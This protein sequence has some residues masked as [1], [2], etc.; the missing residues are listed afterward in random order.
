VRFDPARICSILNEERVDYVVVG[1]LAAV[2]LGSPL[3]TEDID[4]IPSREEQNLERLSRALVRLN[5]RIRTDGDPVPAPLDPLFL[6]QM[7]HILNLVTDFGILDLTF[8]PAGPLAD[9]RQWDEH[10]SAEEIADGLV[11]RVASLDD[12]ID[13]KRAAN[14]EKDLRALPYL[15]S[16]REVR[17]S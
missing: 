2:I 9:Y 15:E 12:I 13:S 1:G 7:S 11:V 17:D 5:A 8:A 6:S 4:V 14:R 10:A 16:L 3:P